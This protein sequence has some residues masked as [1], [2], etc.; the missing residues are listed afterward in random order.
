MRLSKAKGESTVNHAIILCM[1][2][3]D[4]VLCVQYRRSNMAERL[5][6]DIT[7]VIIM[8]G[9]EESSVH[10]STFGLNDDDGGLLVYMYMHMWEGPA[11]L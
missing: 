1:L 7:I 10:G 9:H 4:S 3:Q 11:H 5:A 6:D 2:R 8:H